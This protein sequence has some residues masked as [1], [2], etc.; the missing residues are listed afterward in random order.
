MLVKDW[1]AKGQAKIL[2]IGHD[3]RLQNS[4]TIAEYCLFADYYF[5][6]VPRSG[7]EK[8]KYSLAKNTF[9]QILY[10]TTGKYCAE[11][12]F[13]TNLCNDELTHAPKGKIVLIP[14]EKAKEGL[15]HILGILRNN[16]IEYVFPTS[17]QVNYWLQKLDF[18]NSEE[19]FLEV[20]KPSLK[21]VGNDPPYYAPQKSKSFQKICGK[22]YEPQKCG[23]KVIPI[24][25]PKNYPLKGNFTCYQ[26]SYDKIRSYFLNI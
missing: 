2:V 3:A 20:S 5:G 7:S 6:D 22:V 14:H 21:G 1:E 26:S 17:L 16:Q 15:E 18:Y 10:L 9:E 11:D 12:I 4:D 19:D 25:H 8:K 13:I 24:L 23:Y